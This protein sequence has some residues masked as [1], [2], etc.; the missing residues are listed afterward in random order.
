MEDLT[1]FCAPVTNQQAIVVRELFTNV[2]E[3]KPRARKAVGHLLDV[4][5]HKNA[6]SNEGFVAG[7]KLFIEIVPDFEVDIPLLWQ[8]I[9]QILGAL[10]GAPSS[11]MNLL[12][13][14]FQLIPINKAEQLFNDIIRYAIEFSSETHIE[15]L[16]QSAG[17]S[18]DDFLS[19]DSSI[20]NQYN[21][22]TQSTATS[23]P[24]T[25]IIRETQSP[26]ADSQLVKLFKSINDQTTTVTDEQILDYIHQVNNRNISFLVLISSCAIIL[27]YEC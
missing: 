16:W 19:A 1:S 9:G 6:I 17:L 4:A 24:S 22:L 20:R 23:E 8:Y 2:L 3:A 7:M 15:S 5:I 12:T 11:N 25:P 21:W 18:L 27:E 14:I 10:I 26:H 13:P